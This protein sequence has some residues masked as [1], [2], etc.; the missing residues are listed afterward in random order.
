MED[1]GRQSKL[2]AT[3]VYLL[4]YRGRRR[5]CDDRPR[6]ALRS[7]RD[8]DVESGIG[9]SNGGDDDNGAVDGAVVDEQLQGIEMLISLVCL[10]LQYIFP[11]EEQ[12]S[13][14]LEHEPTISD[15]S[16]IVSTQQ[17]EFR[18]YCE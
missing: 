4:L 2:T 12:N 6:A 5:S 13:A 8:I 10:L 17:D 15:T 14:V 3:R 11:E 7:R 1:I 9:S 18:L 16:S